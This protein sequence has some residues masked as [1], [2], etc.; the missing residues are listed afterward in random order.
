MKKRGISP[1]IATV[2]LVGFV[3]AI[4]VLVWL[5]YGTI[6]EER[7]Q[8][9]RD[10]TTGKF[11][12]ATDVS[13]SVSNLGCVTNINDQRVNFDVQNTGQ[14]DLIGFRVFIEGA[15]GT[16][17]Q[18]LTQSLARSGTITTGVILDTQVG[19]M[20]RVTI[21]PVIASGSSSTTCTDQQIIL[22]CS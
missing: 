18:E 7:A 13:I 15:S 21:M 10:D 1:L 5:W 22:N 20:S 19:T 16:D 3:V 12:C 2:L 4:A 17:T 14:A 8:K 6:I 11:S 9:V